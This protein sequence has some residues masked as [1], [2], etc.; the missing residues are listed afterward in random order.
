MEELL[1]LFSQGILDTLNMVIISLSISTLIGIPLGLLLVVTRPNHLSPN[2]H[3]FNLINAV[4]NIIRSVP[5][6]VLMVAII[7]FTTFIVG[8]PIG[9]RGATVP[10]IVYTA[11]Y[12]ARLLETA[13]LEVEWGIIEAYRAMGASKLQIVTRIILRESRSGIILCLTIATVGLIGSSAMAGAVGAGGLG[14]LALRYGYQ[15]WNL[16]I[17]F[18]TV[19]ILII[20]VQLIQS[21]GNQ[22]SK[23]LNKK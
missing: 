22:L 10:L 8:T 21:L 12:I 13:L 15:Q 16:N 17:M 11:P 2:K 6:I 18:I 19:I 20:I 1:P 7:P 4:I 3:L 23:K 9:I 14:D 5:F